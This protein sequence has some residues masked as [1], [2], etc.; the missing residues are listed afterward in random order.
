M[1]LPFL[2]ESWAKAEPCFHT[3]LWAELGGSAPCRLSEV[4]TL[5]GGISPSLLAMV[6]PLHHLLEFAAT[7]KNC[8][9]SFISQSPA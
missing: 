6:P 9:V 3:T 5:I 2:E 7:V 1:L 4:W 8:S